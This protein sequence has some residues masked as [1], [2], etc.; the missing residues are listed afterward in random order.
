MSDLCVGADGV[1][2]HAPGTGFQTGTN[3][4]LLKWSQP[5]F[6]IISLWLV[7]PSAGLKFA[8][9]YTTN[10]RPMQVLYVDGCSRARVRLRQRAVEE[11]LWK[12]RAHQ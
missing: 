3:R 10:T 2:P 9:V 7:A 1:G 8:T 11:K 6:P 5:L 4:A 12:D